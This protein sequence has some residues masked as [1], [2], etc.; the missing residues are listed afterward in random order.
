MRSPGREAF[1]GRRHRDGANSD[2]REGGLTGTGGGRTSVTIGSERFHTSAGPVTKMP[3]TSHLPAL[4]GPFRAGIEGPERRGR[5]L[6]PYRGPKVDRASV[7]VGQ[8]GQKPGVPGISVTSPTSVTDPSHSRVP[9]VTDPCATRRT[10][11]TLPSRHLTPR[12]PAPLATATACPGRGERGASLPGRQLA[13]PNPSPGASLRV[14][15]PSSGAS[16]RVLNPSS[17]ASLRGHN[18]SRT[19]TCGTPSLLGRQP[20]GRVPAPATASRPRSRGTD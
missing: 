16:L 19:L 18:P 4:G 17:G 1:V 13:G 14:L 11:L 20:A 2:F 8:H 9:A 15:N 5:P 12:T 3:G 6:G 7:A 10:L